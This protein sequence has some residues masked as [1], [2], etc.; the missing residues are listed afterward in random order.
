[1]NQ[2]VEHHVCGE[3][4]VDPIRKFGLVQSRR[5][6][7]RDHWREFP[8]NAYFAGAIVKCQLNKIKTVRIL[9]SE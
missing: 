3:N 9:P 7:N 1:M 4:P 5:E 6:E 8:K 2:N